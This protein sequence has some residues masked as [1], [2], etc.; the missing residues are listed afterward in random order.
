MC[1]GLPLPQCL[2]EFTTSPQFSK[3]VGIFPAFSRLS[4]TVLPVAFFGILVGA[5]VSVILYVLWLYF[6]YQPRVTKSD[7]IVEPEAR[8]VPGQIGAI[9]IPVCLFMFAWTSRER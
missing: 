7:A 1:F 5:V 2:T 9:C 4:L 6:S 3:A 8:L